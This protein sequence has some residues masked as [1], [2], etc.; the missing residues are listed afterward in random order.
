M[1]ASRPLERPDQ[2]RIIV[3]GVNWLGDAVMSTPAL[4]RLREAHPKAFIGL[5]TPGKLADLW[6][7]H[8]AVDTV[9]SFEPGDGLFSIARRVRGGNY[10][11]GLVLPN[12]FQSA[13][14]LRWAAVP[15]RIG[16]A[17]QM[18]TWLLTRAVSQRP[19]AV[20]MRKRSVR[21]IRSLV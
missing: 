15:E 10:D 3:R 4:L 2:S 16:Y 21:E 17:G 12:S 13:L 7:H 20:R 6:Q 8:P 18:R 9:L 19:D 14:E 1:N 5:L 11:L